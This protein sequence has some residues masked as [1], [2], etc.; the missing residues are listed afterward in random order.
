MVSCFIWR[1]VN[2]FEFV[3]VYDVR[4]LANFIDSHVA[5]PLSKHHL[6]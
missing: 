2:N 1:S 3:F 6:L 5:I 4:E